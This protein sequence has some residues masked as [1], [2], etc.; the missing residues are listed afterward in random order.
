MFNGT[1]ALSNPR[2][3]DGERWLGAVCRK[4]HSPSDPGP[5]PKPEPPASS[6]LPNRVPLS[7]PL[8]GHATAEALTG[9]RSRSVP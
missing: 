3:P 1:C 9:T 6:G 5:L 8:S 4:L 7:G 2:P